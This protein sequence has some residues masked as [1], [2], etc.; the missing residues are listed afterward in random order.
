MP[1]R[2]TGFTLAF[3]RVNH[4]SLRERL[5]DELLARFPQRNILL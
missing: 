4:A 5:A 1:G 2:A 3:V